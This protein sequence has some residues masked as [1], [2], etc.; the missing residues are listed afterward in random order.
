MVSHTTAV[1][2]EGHRSMTGKCSTFLG[3]VWPGSDYLR[4]VAQLLTLH[5]ISLHFPGEAASD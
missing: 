1:T 3:S 4:S 5:V 2:V